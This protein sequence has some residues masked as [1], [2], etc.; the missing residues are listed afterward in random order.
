LCPHKSDDVVNFMRV[1]CIIS[2]QLKWYKNYKNRLRLAKVIVK[3]KMPHFL[4]V[5]CVQ[6]VTANIANCVCKCR[7]E[8]NGVYTFPTETIYEGQLRD[9]TFHGLGTLFFP[10]GSKYEG[11]WNNGIAVKVSLFCIPVL[12]TAGACWE[13]D[14]YSMCWREISRSVN[15]VTNI[16]RL[17]GVM[18]VKFVSNQYLVILIS[19]QHLHI[20]LLTYLLT[21]Y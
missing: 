13:C 6:H 15:I 14:V 17:I 5:H 7:L 19:M 2:S 12:M 11:V 4:L 10:N 1:T 8:G 21:L 20:R 18:S 9:G 3:N 16:S